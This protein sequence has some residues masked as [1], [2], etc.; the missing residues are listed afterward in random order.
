MQE[1]SKAEKRGLPEEYWRRLHGWATKAIEEAHYSP[2]SLAEI[3]ARLLSVVEALEKARRTTLAEDIKQQIATFAS[4][5]PTA[6]S[7]A[8][9]SP[10]GV[11]SEGKS[12]QR[13]GTAFAVNSDGILITAFHVVKGAKVIELACP[14]IGTERAVI[15]R[16]SVA[17]DLAVLRISQRKTP[18]YLS[19]ADQ[20]SVTLGQQV[21]TIGYPAPD[22]L[23]SE[24]KFT[25]GVVSSLSVGGDAGY[26][27]I[28][29]PVQPG[30]SG[31]PLLNGSGEVLGSSFRPRPRWR[32]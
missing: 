12:I 10:A 17:N 6:T 30:N 20:K 16:F 5:P 32:F 3:R 14:E 21:F 22:M 29:V 25:E 27:Q 19:I 7:Q 2:T 1:K 15:E 18:S 31:G 24:A 13:V 4:T 23:G 9:S 28:S 11:R 8:P 26:M